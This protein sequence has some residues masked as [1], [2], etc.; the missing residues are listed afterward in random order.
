MQ[1]KEH[2]QP[3][4]VPQVMVSS[5]FT[6]L[7][8]HRAAAITAIHKHKMHANVMEYGGAKPAGDVIDSSLGM[9]REGAGYICLIS[10]KYGQTPKC[11]KKNPDGLS[12]T[13]LEFNEA[14]KRKRPILL[15]IMGDEHPVKKVDIE[16][17]RRKE[18][19]L[20]AFRRKPRN[21]WVR[22]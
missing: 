6:D 9:V 16:R 1:K 19:K 20:D 3:R 14:R 8:Q 7:E 2:Y 5:T 22:S 18:K 11:P 15:F 21:R 10:L 13:E 17:D 12:L 4:S